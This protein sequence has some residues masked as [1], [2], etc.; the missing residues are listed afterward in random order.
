[1]RDVN[2]MRMKHNS[3][4]LFFFI[5]VA[6]LAAI[7]IIKT[8]GGPHPPSTSSPSVTQLSV[9]MRIVSLQIGE[10]FQVNITMTNA[11]DVHVWQT[12]I[13]FNAT[14]LEA[15]SFEEGPFL[16]QIGQTLWV[17]GAID[18]TAGII[19][20][21]AAA[22]VGNATGVDGDGVIGIVTFRVKNQG[23]SAVQLSDVLV[24]D[25]KLE[26]IPRSTENGTIRMKMPGDVDDNGIVDAS[27][28]YRIG[29]GFGI[30]AGENGY[31]V[32]ADLNSDNIIDS[33]DLASLTNHFGEKRQ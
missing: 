27:D 21:S 6:A 25:S 22:L 1:M 13:S 12:G 30:R 31:D 16:K 15:I 8:T 19:H 26:A 14:L 32:E 10:T 2:K 5:G 4:T 29:K 7:S 11:S 24:L 28:L 9:S 3:L 20:Y 18:N 23:E 17:P 33:L